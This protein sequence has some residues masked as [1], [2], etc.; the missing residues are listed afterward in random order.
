MLSNK[1]DWFLV[2]VTTSYTERLSTS[3]GFCVHSWYRNGCCPSWA[4]QKR[5]IQGKVPSGHAQKKPFLLIWPHVVLQLVEWGVSVM[6][7]P[8]LSGGAL[9]T[10][11]WIR[12]WHHD[13][14][15]MLEV[16]HTWKGG[17]DYLLTPRSH[18][19]PALKGKGTAPVN[20]AKICMCWGSFCW[21]PGATAW[22]EWGQRR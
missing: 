20:S 6:E 4:T 11:Q 17:Q 15:P 22:D 10:P 14:Y 9:N 7:M 1:E 2:L 8:P 19:Q 13:F 21:D 5:E 3:E 18:S 12:L 16:N